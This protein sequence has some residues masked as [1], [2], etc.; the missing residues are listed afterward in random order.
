[1]PG[2]IGHHYRVGTVIGTVAVGTGSI[3]EPVRYAYISIPIR[4]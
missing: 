1:M 2:S 3:Y 4:K